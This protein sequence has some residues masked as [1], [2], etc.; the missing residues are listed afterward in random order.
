[1]RFLALVLRYWSCLFALLLGLFLTGLALMIFGFDIHNVDLAMLPWWKGSTL[2]LWLLG[3]GLA[4]ILA[5]ILA[6][7]NRLKPL[8]LVYSVAAF[9]IIVY[10]YFISSAYRFSGKD[11]ALSAFYFALA[12]L[13]AA[14]G[15][16]T[17]FTGARRRA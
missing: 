1:M 9:V 17:Q 4:G 7:L 12:A 10:G 6:L 15:S 13:L 14:I 5:G 3:L 8:L 11:G 16:L 2:T